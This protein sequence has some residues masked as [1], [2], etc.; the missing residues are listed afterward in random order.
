[1]M[2]ERNIGFLLCHLQWKG[3]IIRW[4]KIYSQLIFIFFSFLVV[5]RLIPYP[6]GDSIGSS[7]L[8]NVFEFLDN[9]DSFD[10]FLFHKI[11]T[12]EKSSWKK[13]I[14]EKGKLYESNDG[15]CCCCCYCWDTFL[16]IALWIKHISIWKAKLKYR[17]PKNYELVWS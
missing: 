1:M 10:S 12:E 14:Y 4:T 11:A 3:W 17:M 15:F 2:D 5:V 13:K 9:D 16:I 8:F 7:I 6:Y